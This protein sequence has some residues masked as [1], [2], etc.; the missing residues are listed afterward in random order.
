MTFYSLVRDSNVQK[1]SSYSSGKERE[2]AEER[3]EKEAER[4]LMKITR[5][6][7]EEAETESERDN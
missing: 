2:E 1:R 3:E 6:I 5:L 7:D 4:Q